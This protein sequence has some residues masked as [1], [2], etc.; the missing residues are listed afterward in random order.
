MTQLEQFFFGPIRFRGLFVMRAGFG[1]IAAFYYLRLLPYL[2]VFF[3]PNGVGGYATRQR[4]PS[5]PV[6]TTEGLEHFELLSGVSSSGVVWALWAALLLAA[7]SFAVGFFTRP[8]GLALAA[9][10]VVFA[11]HQPRLMSGWT[12][13]YPTFV[14]YLTLAPSGAAW[15]LDAWR[16]GRTAAGNGAAVDF[17]PW[18]FRL[19]QIHVWAMYATAGWPRL[20]GRAWLRGETVLHAVADTRFGRWSLD[21]HGLQPLLVVATYYA[22]VMEPAATLLLPFGRTRRWCA[23]GLLALHLGIELVADIGMWQF[24]MATAVLAFLPDAWFGWLP[25]LRTSSRPS[26]QDVSAATAP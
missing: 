22:L 9:L 26:D 5:F 1:L 8:A 6:A 17:N 23:L 14:L 10:H 11:A 15:S 20:A 4:W 13:L 19:L 3:G 12:Q 7:L 16:R 25:G 21:W 24:T 2:Q 18:A